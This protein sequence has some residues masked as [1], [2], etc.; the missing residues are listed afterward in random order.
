MG[1]RETFLD[2]MIAQ[3]GYVRDF[4]K[5]LVAEDLDFMRA[6]NGLMEAGYMRQRT[7]E[8]KTKELIFIGILVGNGAG[9]EHIRTHMEAAKRAGA[10]KTEVLEALEL[11]VSPCG[12]PRFLAGYEVWTELY[13]VERV[14]P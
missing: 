12:V 13:P 11:T 2:E 10:T 6:V 14:D 5:V 7:L 8:Q 9:K 4:H 3:R 1:E